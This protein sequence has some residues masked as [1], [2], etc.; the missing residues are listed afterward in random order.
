MLFCSMVLKTSRTAGGG[1]GRVW[2]L[3]A[4]DGRF[5]VAERGPIGA[6]ELHEGDGVAGDAAGVGAG[7][8]MAG[9][10][11]NQAGQML[12]RAIT[13]A[14][15][16]EA[17]A[18]MWLGVLR[19]KQR[20]PEDEDVFYRAAL[21]L[22]EPKSDDAAPILELHAQL[23]RA[24]NKT[25][26]AGELSEQASVIRKGQKVEPEYSQEARLARMGKRKTF[27]W[28]VGTG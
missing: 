1:N 20:R 25:D 15:K 13:V 17:R 26:E 27:N 28:C 12:E 5:G 11:F 2:T 4:E 21:L 19:E 10:N 6:T 7:I 9:K 8:E 22:A 23:L 16:S 18:R 3:A 14:P 24:Q